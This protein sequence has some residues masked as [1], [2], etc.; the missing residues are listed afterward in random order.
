MLFSSANLPTP[1]RFFTPHHH[2]FPYGCL[3]PHTHRE[4]LKHVGGRGFSFPG[5]Y[6]GC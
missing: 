2:T 3:P 6:Y 5:P 1:S 4:L